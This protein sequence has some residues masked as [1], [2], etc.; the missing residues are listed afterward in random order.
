MPECTDA[1]TYNTKN[2]YYFLSAACVNCIRRLTSRIERNALRS[3]CGGHCTTLL[4]T[5]SKCR[6]LSLPRFSCRKQCCAC[7]CS[8]PLYLIFLGGELRRRRCCV[9][10]VPSL[11]RAHVC[12]PK[13]KTIALHRT[14]TLPSCCAAPNL[15]FGAQGDFAGAREDHRCL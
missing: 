6:S 8:R 5:L 14:D 11:P 13:W 2:M 9:V 10:L 12:V 7:S 1:N 15:L 3:P 4:Y